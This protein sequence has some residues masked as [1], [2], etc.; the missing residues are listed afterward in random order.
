MAPLNP[1]K[2]CSRFS[3]ITEDVFKQ[4]DNKSLAIC[5]E[6]SK[7]WKQI[8][9]NKKFSWNRI[10]KIPT[11]PQNGNA[12]LHIAA[13]TGQSTMFEKFL[14]N[15]IDKNL[16]NNLGENPTHLICQQGQKNQNTEGR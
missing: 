3:H 16:K 6:V 9:E 1:L 10:V 7:P 2:F 8:I 15:E 4:L 12:Y 11:I 5:R 13:R 14:E